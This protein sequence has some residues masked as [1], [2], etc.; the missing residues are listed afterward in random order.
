MMIY[1]VKHCE[2][3]LDNRPLA[4]KNGQRYFWRERGYH[5]VYDVQHALQ[6]LPVSE[7]IIFSHLEET[8]NTSEL[9]LK[10]SIR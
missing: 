3:N 6:G 2:Q 1:T 4:S 5:E 7:M 8:S 9:L 10:F